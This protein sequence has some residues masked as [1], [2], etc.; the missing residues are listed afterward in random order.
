M[1]M[2][3]ILAIETSS[4]TASVALLQGEAIH[5]VSTSGFSNHSQSVLPMLQGLLDKT[6]I[7]LPDCDAIAFGCGPGS[8]TGVRTAC[9]ITQGL[10]FGS[11]LPVIPVVTL[12]AMAHTCYTKTGETNILVILDARMKEVYWAQYRYGNGWESVVE[13]R[14]SPASEVMPSGA[15]HLCGNGF[16]AY[17]PD[18]SN[19]LAS[20]P[21]FPD[22]APDAV[23]IA[24]LGLAAFMRGDIIQAR[25]AQPLYLRNKVAQ[26][27]LE[28][29]AKERLR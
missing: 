3:T 20:L 22:I 2:A 15:V 7:R 27:T 28:R 13:P 10:A 18:F 29:L 8:F 12:Q 16:A 17:Q 14:L 19:A 23:A 11:G 4:D 9:G 21:F 1:R 24:Q 5:A 25:D 6:G 26:T